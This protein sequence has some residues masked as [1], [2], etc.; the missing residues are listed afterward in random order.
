LRVEDVRAALEHLLRIDKL[1]GG[2][3]HAEVA[4]HGIGFPPAYEL[5]GIL[6]DTGTQES[7]GATGVQRFGADE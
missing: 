4:E 5:D 6:V 3:L 7:S 2:S 1:D